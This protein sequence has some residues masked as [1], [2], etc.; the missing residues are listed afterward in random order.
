MRTWIPS[1]L[2]LI[3]LCAALAGFLAPENPTSQ[4]RD[5][6]F[7]PPTRLHFVDVSGRFHVRPFVRPSMLRE[8]SID[9]YQED[10]SREYPVRFF[11][12]G[13]PYRL[14]GLIDA[15]RHLF[16]TGSP[17]GLFLL[18]TDDLG[19]DVFSR[20]LY[21]SQISLLSGLLGTAL[22]LSAALVLG[23][24]AGYYGTWVD[25]IIMRVGELFLAL[26]WLYLLFAVRMA[27]PLH[28][29]PLQAF[30]LILLVIGLVG[31]A[32]PARLIRGVVLSARAREFVVAARCAGASDVYVFRRHVL[33]Q[34]LGVMLTQAAVLAPQFI[35][36][37]VTLSFF[38]LGVAEPVPSWGNMLAGLQRYHVLTS[39]WWMFAPGLA[40]VPV[41]LLFYSLADALHRRSTRASI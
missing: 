19:R 17:T 33:P 31:W 3:Y 41:S 22:T 29:E 12:R 40:L 35:L 6:P 34:V 2:G 11:V 14:L 30:I 20:L 5:F 27:L 38:G 4:H 39:Y 21:G 9:E 10:E 7:A 8:N 28:I 36:A 24:L 26:P 37:E 18:G 32:R 25:D 16:G 1:A 15:D 23:G 13:A